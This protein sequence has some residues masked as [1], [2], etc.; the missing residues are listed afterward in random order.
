MLHNKPDNFITWK[1]SLFSD[2]WAKLTKDRFIL[3]TVCHRYKIEVESEPF[4][5]CNRKPIN[6]NLKKQ[7]IISS[8]LNS[9]EQQEDHDGPISLT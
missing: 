2:K 7:D 8:L 3:D 4:K 5:E 9:F 6:F 1:I